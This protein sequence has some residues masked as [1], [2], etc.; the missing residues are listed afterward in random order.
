MQY[1]SQYCILFQVASKLLEFLLKLRELGYPSHLADVAINGLQCNV[2]ADEADRMVSVS[3]EVVCS[4]P[5]YNFNS[6]C[7]H[8]SQI[9]VIPYLCEAKELIVRLMQENI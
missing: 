5:T 2:Q 1:N 4:S 7:N 8:N 9:F 6:S 3:P